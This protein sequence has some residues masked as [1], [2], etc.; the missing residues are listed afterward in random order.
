MNAQDEALEQREVKLPESN[1]QLLENT[2]HEGEHAH[3]HDGIEHEDVADYAKS[4][5]GRLRHS[6]AHVLAGALKDLYPD[7]QLA[8]GPAIEDGFYYDIDIPQPLSEEDFPRLEA[9]MKEVIAENLPFQGRVVSRDAALEMFKDA[10]YKLEIIRDL[11]EGAELRVYS[12]GNFTDL[13]RG[14]HTQTT[15]EIGAVKLMSVAG[16]Y[17]RGDEKRPMLQRIYGTA[18]QTQEQL[19]NYL[20]RLEEAKRRDHRK[21]GKELGLFIIS[22]LVGPG[23]PLF[24]PKGEAIRNEMEKYV[25]EVQTRYGYQHVRTGTI[26]RKELYRQSGHLEHYKDSMY[27]LMEDPEDPDESYALKPMNCPHHFVLYK[28]SLRSYRDLPLRYAEF[29]TLYRYERSGQL[30]GLARVRSLTQDDAHVICRPDQVGDEFARALKIIQEVLGTYGLHDYWIRLSLH[31]PNNANKYGE[32]EVWERAEDTLREVMDAMGIQYVAVEGEAAFYGPKMDLMVRDVLGR[33]W[34]L[35]T[36]QVDMVQPGRFNME[37]IGEDGQPHRPVVLHRAVTGATERTLAMLIEHYAGAFPVWLAPVQVVVIPISDIKHGDYAREVGEKL[38]AAGL[39]I[40][41]NDRNEP[42]RAKIRDA[43]L[44]KVPYMLIIGD[45]EL[46]ANAVAVRL[47]SGEDLG[48]QPVDEFIARI[49]E[50]VRTRQQ[51]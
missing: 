3:L 6:A 4:E 43:Q 33:E 14:G 31:D 36:I 22:D 18:W 13:C 50:E 37:Y 28:S 38:Q 40:E 20:Y 12:H 32:T 25:R 17:W 51:E 46:A 21:L 23:L 24:L 30:L 7:V 10:P 19:D 44:Q 8:I 2:P 26:G 48:P 34:Q 9:R 41:V 5:L 11:P 15:G 29:T 39:R 27:P 47:R 35:S 1:S 16:A 49:V 45:K 42:M